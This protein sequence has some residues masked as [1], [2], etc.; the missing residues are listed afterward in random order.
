MV[1]VEKTKEED[2]VGGQHSRAVQLM[3]AVVVMC[4]KIR[5]PQQ[6]FQATRI[7]LTCELN[8]EVGLHC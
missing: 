1:G 5:N 3:N 8:F 7:I 6:S 4:N 2:M